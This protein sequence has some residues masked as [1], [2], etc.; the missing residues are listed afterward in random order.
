VF[1]QGVIVIDRPVEDVYAF[2]ADLKNQ[3]TCWEMLY[4]PDL[5][6]LPPMS[7]EA[8]GTYQLGMKNHRCDIELYFTRPGAGVVTRVRWESGELAAEW[9]IMESEG[10]TKIEL[11]IEGHGG[12]LATSVPLRQ[13]APRILGR[14]KQHFD[15]A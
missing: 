9:R 5:D 8:Q 7:I 3:L 14:V 15:K 12:G 6:S 10:R 1:T 11:N 2:V 4:V 13:M